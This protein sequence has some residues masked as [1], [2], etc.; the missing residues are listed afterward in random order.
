MVLLAFLAGLALVVA[1]ATL[2]VVRAVGLWRQ[3]KRTGGALGAEL[4]S[5]EERAART[6]RLL[7]EA[8]RASGDLDAALERLR[9]SRARLQVLL[10]AL[11]RAQA[12]V[13][14]LRAFVPIR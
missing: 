8:D 9:V 1:G 12:R 4:S 6:E 11:D 7:A 14:W 5:F 10:G 2:T 3:A 13:G